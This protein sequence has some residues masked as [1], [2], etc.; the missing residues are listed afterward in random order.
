MTALNDR[1]TESANA[2]NVIVRIRD[3]H[4]LLRRNAAQS[5]L[6]R[7]VVP[8]SIEALRDAGVFRIA[9]PKR[10]G[11]YEASVRTMLDVSS[12]VGE[13]DGGTAWVVALLNVCA[14]L[15]SLFPEA[16]QDDVWGSDPDALVSGVLAPSCES[17][18]VEGGHRVSGR[19]FWNSGSWHASWAVLGLPITDA[20]GNAVDQGL[21]LIPRSDLELEETWF[22]AGMKS[23]GSNCLI[24][25]DVFVP[26]HR[27][28]SVPAAIEGNYATEHADEVPYRAAFVPV[29][30]LVLTG[31]QLGLG[32]AALEIVKS[33]AATKPISYTFYTAQADSVAFQ[34]QLA[35]A[36]M[37]I[38]T[39]HLHAYRAAEDIDAAAGQGEYLDLITRARVRADTGWAVNHVVDAINVLLSAHGASSF[40]DS[41]PLQ[42]IWRDSS[43][44]ARHAVALPVVGYEVYGKALLER[45]DQITPLV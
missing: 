22:V 12:A 45:P 2:E 15:A 17:R 18:K 8:E 21:A 23:T 16:A 28:I 27:I 41:N 32:R 25:K 44:A 20:S 40:A 6:D 34:L 42:R 11:G 10:H 39:A 38:D 5:E 7:R 33:K 26:D 13:A 43:V 35:E 4:S 9:Q 37:M 14:W 30:A 24:A 3:L 29:L 19:W 36:A 31:P 1:A